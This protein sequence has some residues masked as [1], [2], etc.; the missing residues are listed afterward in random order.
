MCLKSQL[1]DMTCFFIVP[2]I[3]TET[4]TNFIKL[5]FYFCVQNFLICK[6]YIKNK[7]LVRITFFLFLIIELKLAICF[8]N[9]FKYN[10]IKF[11]FTRFTLIKKIKKMYL[12]KIKN[13][14]HFMSLGGSNLF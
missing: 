3:P 13:K 11:S 6:A 9:S 10:Q 1:I 2:K 8:R 12:K 7:L 5:N 14:N 4:K